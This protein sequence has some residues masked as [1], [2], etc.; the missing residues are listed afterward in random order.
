MQ[1]TTSLGRIFLAKTPTCSLLHACVQLEQTPVHYSSNSLL[2]NL[3]M[4]RLSLTQVWRMWDVS[5]LPHAAGA[6]TT[7]SPRG[8]HRM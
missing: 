6:V 7:E 5:S 4:T 1:I 8:R 3:L 2:V